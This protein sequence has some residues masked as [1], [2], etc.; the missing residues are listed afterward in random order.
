MGNEF[1][2][3]NKE[4]IKISYPS[5]FDYLKMRVLDGVSLE[6]LNLIVE[7]SDV[8]IFSGIIRDYFLQNNKPIR[9][10]DIVIAHNI[11]WLSIIRKYHHLTQI[12]KNSFGG[13]KIRINNLTIDLWS[14]KD[15]WGIIHGKYKLTPQNL[16]RTAFF[17]FS[18]IL[19]SIRDRQFY[20]HKSFSSFL[21]N[22][23]IDVVY[24]VNPNI[25]LCI[26]NSLHYSRTLKMNLSESLKRWIIDHFNINY[27]YELTQQ[28]HW[29]RIQYTN[30]EIFTFC[31]HCKYSLKK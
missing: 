20:I 23:E 26:I 16:I 5:F 21:Y 14:L 15:T 7:Q 13:Y 18:A 2:Y 9:D 30:D 22:K 10:I 17:N 25:P 4:I 12:T 29:H 3:N 27:N 19:Y 11:N 8:Y 24:Q 31:L 28:K 6:I 1:N